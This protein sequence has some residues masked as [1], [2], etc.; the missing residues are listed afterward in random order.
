[1]PPKKSKTKTSSGKPSAKSAKPQKA[2]S[3]NKGWEWA[4]FT[5]KAFGFNQKARDLADALK[6]TYGDNVSISQYEKL[7]AAIPSMTDAQRGLLYLDPKIVILLKDYRTARAARDSERDNFR[8]D[9]AIGNVD[10]GLEA[11]E[12]L[13]LLN[14][15][16]KSQVTLFEDDE[17]DEEEEDEP[18]E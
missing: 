7:I 17:D 15:K 9:I 14:E 11:L 3:A 5:K 2:D 16:F 8:G 18:K 4:P 13:G 1:M 12:S 10:T 6:S